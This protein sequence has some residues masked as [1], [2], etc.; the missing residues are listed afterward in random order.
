[1]T[2]IATTQIGEF[3]VHAVED[4]FFTR[5]ARDMFPRSAPEHWT[6][7]Q[8]GLLP[9]G[10][11]RITF[12]C[13]IVVGPSGVVLVDTGAGG[14]D[15]GLPAA[16]EHLEIAEADVTDIVHTHL[17]PDHTGGDVQ[18][19]KLAFPGATFHVHEREMAYWFD[20]SHDDRERGRTP[21]RPVI[22]A[23]RHHTVTGDAEIA[24]HL[25]VVESF[26]HTPGHVSVMLASGNERMF[27]TGDVTHHPLQAVHP[28]WSIPFDIDADTARESRRQVFQMLADTDITI[29][30]GHYPRPGLGRLTKT[31]NAYEWKWMG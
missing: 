18:H 19:G 16:L 1:M 12:G 23:G 29:G 4:G 31:T 27:I 9:S 30:C 2:D 14:D 11:L 21:Y 7:D 6:A 24:G 5:S 10:D 15:A 17:H 3:T 28:E 22:D 13:F 25:T 20:E 8:P 26:G